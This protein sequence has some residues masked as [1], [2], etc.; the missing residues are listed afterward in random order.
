M[1]Q[2]QSPAVW[3]KNLKREKSMSIKV[4]IADDHKMMCEGLHQQLSNSPGIEVVGEATNGREAPSN[5]LLSS[6]SQVRI[7]PGTPHKTAIHY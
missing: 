3:V 7:L 5:Y 6:G 2:L 4:L 1:S